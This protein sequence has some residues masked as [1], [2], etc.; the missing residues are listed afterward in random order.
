MREEFKTLW[1]SMRWALLAVAAAALLA[2]GTMASLA[3][4]SNGDPEQSLLSFYPALYTAGEL[5]AWP[6]GLLAKLLA[7]VIKATLFFSTDPTGDSRNPDDLMVGALLFLFLMLIF[8]LA[9]AAVWVIALIA[10]RFAQRQRLP[11]RLSPREEALQSIVP[12]LIWLLIAEHA[13]WTAGL[14]ACRLTGI[15]EVPGFVRYFQL[16]AADHVPLW[17]SLLLLGALLV[18]KLLLMLCLCLLLYAAALRGGRDRGRRAAWTL[19][20]LA[21]AAVLA[22]PGVIHVGV[23]LFDMFNEG[24]LFSQKLTEGEGAA[25]AFL[26]TGSTLLCAVGPALCAVAACAAVPDRPKESVKT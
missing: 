4:S 14:L 21:G 18:F 23:T 6:M 3:L 20:L 10:R 17:E 25:G 16:M 1:R 8:F 26:S 11:S 7:V 2:D 15:D 24:F 13:I 9:A 12:A 5:L 19:L 22:G